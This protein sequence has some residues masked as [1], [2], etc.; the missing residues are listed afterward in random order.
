MNRYTLSADSPRWWWT[1]GLAGTTAVTA[2]TTLFVLAVAGTSTAYPT[3]PHDAGQ[4]AKAPLA[5]PYESPC[6]NQPVSWSAAQDGPLPRC[7]HPYG[8]LQG[9]AS[10]ATD[11]TQWSSC[12]GYRQAYREC[13]RV[14][15]SMPPCQMYNR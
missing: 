10:E 5:E 15:N 12:D 2:V 1:T 14:R 6:F 7:V 9:F 13:L 11:D 4:P 8:H 3:Q